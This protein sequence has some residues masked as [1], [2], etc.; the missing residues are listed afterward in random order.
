MSQ[1]EK[2]SVLRKLDSGGMAEVFVGEA[3]GIEGF[4]KRVAIKRV[5]PHLA[6]NAKFLTMFLDE[7]RL[8]LR[9]NH[10]NVVQVFDIGRSGGT[11]FI[12]MEYVDGTNLKRVMETMREKGTRLPVAHAVYI[13]MEVCKGLAYAHAL[14]D[15]DGKSYGIVHRDVS[16]PNVLLSK[17]GE[18]KIVDFGLARATSQ[19]ER[20]DPGVV[21]GKFAYLAPEAAWGRP[22][23]HRA[24]IFACGIIL[25][26]LLTGRRLFL[27]ETDVQTVELVRLG[28]VPS[29]SRQNPD[30]PAELEAIVD[31]ALAKDP[32]DRFQSCNDLGEILAGFL[33]SKRLKVTGFDLQR[34]VK[35]IVADDEARDVQ[36]PSIIDKLIEDELQKFSTLEDEV[37]DSVHDLDPA[38]RGGEFALDP[39]GFEDPRAWLGE[40]GV[41]EGDGPLAG[42]DGWREPGLEPDDGQGHD[43]RS[44]HEPVSPAAAREGP[45]LAQMLEGE[46]RMG[47][48]IRHEEDRSRKWLLMGV[49]VAAFLAFAM[50]V[51]ILAYAAGVVP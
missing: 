27:G 26:E 33:F 48:E 40:L 11:Y 43:A 24:D 23:D 7:A 10:A 41:I 17:Q 21:K 30:V 9:M 36:K 4:K 14:T 50:I 3:E 49:G 35:T 51:A 2:Y 42:G 1:R 31:K 32:S 47:S 25:Y 13:V 16:P 5:L 6:E 38:D 18:V 15:H 46:V 45:S 20:T 28:D 39:S 19:L 44:A 34:V 37:R 22:V 8:S 12:V 29:V